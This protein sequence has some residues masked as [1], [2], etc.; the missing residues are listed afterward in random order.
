LRGGIIGVENLERDLT[1]R[2]AETKSNDR[3]IGGAADVGR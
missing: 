1:N 2:R 3:D